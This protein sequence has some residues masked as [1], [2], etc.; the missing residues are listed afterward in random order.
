ME[1][2]LDAIAEPRRREILRL[3][4]RQQL[5]S[6]EIASR[7]DVTRSAI[8]QHLRILERVGLVSVEQAG[9]RRLYRARPEGLAG[10]REYLEE[11]WGD[12]LVNLKQA[13]E[14]Q[15][16]KEAPWRRS[17]GERSSSRSGSRRDRKRSSRS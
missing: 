8:S 4:L 6:G 14:N 11:F 17:Q 3:V 9:T 16:R 12:R 13:V 1:A 2:V 15:E 5:S 7:F 10:L